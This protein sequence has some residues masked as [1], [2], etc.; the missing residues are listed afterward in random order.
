VS[1]PDPR[2]PLRTV[3]AV[4]FTP[5]AN[6]VRF[7]ECGH[8]ARTNPTMTVR[9]GDP[10]RCFACGPHGTDPTPARPSSSAGARGIR[11]WVQTGRGI[12]EDLDGRYRVT[13]RRGLH[14]LRD[15]RTGKV[16]AGQST[17]PRAQAA[18]ERLAAGEGGS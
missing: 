16:Y 10:C 14:Y 11:G 9:V 12:I 13:T 7:A 5:A 17:R 1:R 6:L 2:G 15:L 18:A 8:E 4:T 3:R